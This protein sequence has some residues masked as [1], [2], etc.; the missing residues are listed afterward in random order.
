MSHIR[1]IV[2]IPFS[3][4]GRLTGGRRRTTTGARL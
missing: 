2:S 3:A 4:L 1:K